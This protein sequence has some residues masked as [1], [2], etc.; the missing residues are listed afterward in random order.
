MNSEPSEEH[1][2]AIKMLVAANSVNVSQPISMGTYNQVH[3]Q[4]W[5]KSG[6]TSL[7]SLVVKAQSSPDLDNWTDVSG[8]SVTLTKAPNSGVDA[9]TGTSNLLSAPFLRLHF[10]GAAK[11]TLVGAS[12]RLFN[13]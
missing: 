2:V 3:M 10:T 5:I 1:V 13:A 7:G 6:T 9:T 8:L 11:D 4:I 12:V